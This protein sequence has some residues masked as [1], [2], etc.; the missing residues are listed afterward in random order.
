[1]LR[2]WRWH[3]GARRRAVGFALL[4][5]VLQVLAPPGFMVAREAGRATIA[6][7]TG[8]GP[9]YAL[10]DLAGH[11]AKQPKSKPDA[12]CAFAGH[13]VVA[14]PPI[15]ALIASPVARPRAPLVAARL[16][17]APGRGLAAPPPPSQGPPNFTL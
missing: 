6:I 9:A 3:E 5:L 10:A 1:M 12:P 15:A 7:C 17:L 8:H 4:A 2:T 14:S 13:V 16:D 11:P